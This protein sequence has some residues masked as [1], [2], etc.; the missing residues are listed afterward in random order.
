MLKRVLKD[1]GDIIMLMY[2]SYPGTE[3]CTSHQE[4]LRVKLYN[5]AFIMPNHEL[6]NFTLM[7]DIAVLG[8]FGSGRKEQSRQNEKQH[9]QK[10]ELC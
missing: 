8:T 2:E 9:W 5:P 6:H 3:R 1:G 10:Q 7:Y 4:R